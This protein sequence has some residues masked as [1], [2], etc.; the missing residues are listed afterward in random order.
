M[1]RSRQSEGA[2]RDLLSGLDLGAPTEPSI[3]AIV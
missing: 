3:I 1:A 2:S